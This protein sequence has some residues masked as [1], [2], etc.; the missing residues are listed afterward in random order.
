[1]YLNECLSSW[2]LSSSRCGLHLWLPLYMPNP[3]DAIHEAV[4][5][6]LKHL[7]NRDGHPDQS[8]AWDLDGP[9][10]DCRPRFR[11]AFSCLTS[12]LLPRHRMLKRCC[13]HATLDKPFVMIFL[14]ITTIIVNPSF[15]CTHILYS[16]KGIMSVHVLY[17]YVL[18]LYL[19]RSW[20]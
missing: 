19:W 17:P 14:M 3:R 4:H 7:I 10:V 6:H 1:M 13:L 15:T 2:S 12:D 9:P 5:L 8:N 18:T 20:F 11:F 16:W